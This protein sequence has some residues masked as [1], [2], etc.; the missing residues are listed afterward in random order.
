MITMVRKKGAKFGKMNSHNES[1]FYESFLD[2][3]KLWR[4]ANEL[5][6]SGRVNIDH[7]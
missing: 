6:G 2:I 1:T 7:C 4:G 5:L 3:E